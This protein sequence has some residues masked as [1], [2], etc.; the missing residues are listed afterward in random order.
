MLGLAGY[1]DR[2]FAESFIGL[3]IVQPGL[4]GLSSFLYE[5]NWKAEFCV[6]GAFEDKHLALRT[7]PL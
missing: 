7:P 6:S 2:R 1:S 5:S 3:G 4:D